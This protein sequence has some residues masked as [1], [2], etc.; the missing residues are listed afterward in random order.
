M[1]FFSAHKSV[2]RVLAW[3]LQKPEEGIGSPE[4]E[5]MVGCEL[6]CAFWEL[7]LAPLEEQSVSLTTEPSLRYLLTR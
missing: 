4:T 3:C 7:N 6:P 2:H 5:V 1:F